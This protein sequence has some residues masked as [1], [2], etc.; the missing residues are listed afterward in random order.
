M[1][2]VE[3]I[4]KLGNQPRFPTRELLATTTTMT[5]TF[6]LLWFGRSRDVWHGSYDYE[7]DKGAL[8]VLN[9]RAGHRQRPRNHSIT[10]TTSSHPA[11]GRTQPKEE[12]IYGSY[13]GEERDGGNSANAAVQDWSRNAELVSS[14]GRLAPLGL[15]GL[16]N[17]GNTCFISSVLQVRERERGD[18]VKSKACH[19]SVWWCA[20]LCFLKIF[21]LFWRGAGEKTDPTFDR[22][23]AILF[24]FR[25]PQSQGL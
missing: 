24:P 3:T 20:C 18:E 17:L 21:H 8:G 10:E 14:R 22:A 23:A 5:M 11:D 12:S 16:N 9:W 2:C 13:L 7:F 1:L 6:A 25:W 15:R 19:S 4:C